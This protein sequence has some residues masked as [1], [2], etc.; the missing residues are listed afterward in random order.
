MREEENYIRFE[1]KQGTTKL[2]MEFSSD[3][4][5]P[6]VLEQLRSFMLAMGYAKESIDD[7]V[8]FED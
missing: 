5:V 7:H 2:R 4:S 1:S 6:E 8:E 3:S